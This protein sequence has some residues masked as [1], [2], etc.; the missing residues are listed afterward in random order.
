MTEIS[1]SFFLLFPYVID[2]FLPFVA[3][4]EFWLY[5]KKARH[6]YYYAAKT[7]AAEA[8]LRISSD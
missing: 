5:T 8:V 6:I 4:H 1:R 2:E 7:H 3:F